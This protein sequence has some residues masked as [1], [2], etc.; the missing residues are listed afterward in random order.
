MGVTPCRAA[1]FLRGNKSGTAEEERLCLLMGDKGVLPQLRIEKGEL[2]IMI[3]AKSFSFSVRI[4]KLCRM[5][6][7]QR[8]EFILSNQLMRS[9]CS[10]GANVSEAQQGQSRA[11]FLS[12][13]SI[14]LK[15]A[16]ETD[17]WLRLLHETGYL[18]DREFDSI[19]RDCD[20][21]RRILASIVKTT[22]ENSIQK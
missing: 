3:A 2:R 9:G 12:K 10:I 4:V 1:A 7:E 19:Y 11:D 21:I 14:A 15:E 18:T 13:N 20:E 16:V 17:Y 22:R 6:R 8:K 5:L